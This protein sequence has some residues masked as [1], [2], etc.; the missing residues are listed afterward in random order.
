MED[1]E[2]LEG[3]FVTKEDVLENQKVECTDLENR[4]RKAEE[5]VVVLKRQYDKLNSEKQE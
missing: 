4:N 3:L 1:Y 2:N 5:E